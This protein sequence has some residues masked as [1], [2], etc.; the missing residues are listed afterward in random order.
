MIGSFSKRFAPTFA[1]GATA[2]RRMANLSIVTMTRRKFVPGGAPSQIFL[3]ASENRDLNVDR[4]CQG[5]LGHV[6]TIATDNNC[7]TK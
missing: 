1:Y 3:A 6:T 5:T 2:Y 7:I 4:K